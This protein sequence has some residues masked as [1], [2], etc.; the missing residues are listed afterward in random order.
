MSYHQH[1]YPRLPMSQAFLDLLAEAE[2]LKHDQQ[3]MKSKMSEAYNLGVEYDV[4][5]SQF[6]KLIAQVRIGSCRCYC[7]SCCCCCC[8]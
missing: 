6:K 7:C 5:A 2:S 1:S 3:K 4:P 8:C